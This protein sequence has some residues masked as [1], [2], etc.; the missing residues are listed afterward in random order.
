MQKGTHLCKTRKL[1]SR[2]LC[3]VHKYT[4][5]FNKS[6]KI[7]MGTINNKFMIMITISG[8]VEEGNYKCIAQ[9]FLKM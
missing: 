2:K 8:E 9:F 3:N 6:T 1:K 7:H 4:N 5:I